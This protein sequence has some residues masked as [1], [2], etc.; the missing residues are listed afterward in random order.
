LKYTSALLLALSLTSA[1]CVSHAP[2][3]PLIVEAKIFEFNPAEFGFVLNHIAESTQLA[4]PVYI[5]MQE[6]DAPVWGRHRFQTGA[7][8][9]EIEARQCVPGLYNTLIHEWAHAMVAEGPGEEY[10]H[11]PLWGAAYAECYRLMLE[12]YSLYSAQLVENGDISGKS[13]ADSPF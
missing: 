2:R 5:R 9:I 7:H 1:S 11:G 12:G 3:E 8:F 10:D 6:I 4:H 13:V